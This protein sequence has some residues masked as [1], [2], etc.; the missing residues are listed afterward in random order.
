MTF[1]LNSSGSS[2]P[3]YDAT[4]KDVEAQ[5]SELGNHTVNH[6]HAD[7]TGCSNYLGSQDLEI[8]Q[9]STYITSRLNQSAVWTFAYPFGDTGWEPAAPSRF[10]LARG[11]FTGMIAPNDSTDPF[12]L[13]IYA[14][15]GGEAASVF[16][17]D[18]DNA[19]TQGRWLI[20]L[21]HSILPDAQNWYAGVDI[22]SVTGS[23]DHAKGLANVWIDSVVNIGAYWRA[24][25]MF[26]ALAPTT[27]GSTMTWTW[28]L[29]AHFPPGKYLRVKV[30]GGTLAQG[31][32][33]LA[34]D[35]HGYYEI[36]LDAGTL[37]LSP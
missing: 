30:D 31:G 35:S 28:T 15:A 27:S 19:V 1:Y 24:E 10:F 3:G 29:P 12:N 17:T 26:S 33:P 32:G 4:W 13:P 11:V 16:S 20:F 18:I 23:I 7:G 22:S 37:S 9:C 5:G 8:D 34:W 2:Y 25:K 14:A 21:F 6:C 36:A